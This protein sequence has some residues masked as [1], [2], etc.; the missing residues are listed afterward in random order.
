MRQTRGRD[1][2]SLPLTPGP[3]PEGPEGRGEKEECSL[4]PSPEV[5]GENGQEVLSAEPD[6]SAT[7]ELHGVHIAQAWIPMRDGVRLAAN[8]SL[9]AGPI[10]EVPQREREQSIHSL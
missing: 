7:P 6:D 1:Y 10:D 5:T 3:S 8:L 4:G 2:S 9:P